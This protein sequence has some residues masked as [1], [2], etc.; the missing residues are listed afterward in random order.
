MANVVERPIDLEGLRT[1]AAVYLG[2]ERT[3]IAVTGDD[4]QRWLNG[5]V[6]NDILKLSG[7]QYACALT[8]KGKIIADAIV[9]AGADAMSVW[10]PNRCAPP[11]VQHWDRFVIMDDVELAIDET[12]HLVFVQG[13][14]ATTAVERAGLSSR[15]LAY[16]DL[17]ASGGVL[18]EV[19]RGEA[20]EVIKRIAREG[21][22]RIEASDVHT[23]RVEAGRASFDFDFDE[24]TYVQEAG[25]EK[26]GVSFTKGCYH[27]QEVVCMLENRGHVNKRLVQVS[28]S[29]GAPLLAG[30]EVSLDGKNIGKLTSVVPHADGTATGLAMI[31]LAHANDGQKLAIADRVA[32]VRKPTW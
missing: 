4:R 24:K 17:G 5:V 23:L 1:G 8:E 15:A 26:R 22:T 3:R 31:K 14:A 19:T 11:L 30:A 32:E 2:E 16:D 25:L 9:V 10:V 13:H 7:A 28:I 21:A 29:P 18:I 12:H 27:G 6:S 20:E